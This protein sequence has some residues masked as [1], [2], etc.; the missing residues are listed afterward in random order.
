MVNSERLV[1]Y[2]GRTCLSTRISLPAVS[3][4][5][6]A[7]IRPALVHRKFLR[8]GWLPDWAARAVLSSMPRRWSRCMVSA[9][10]NPCALAPS[11]MPGRFY[12]SDA[13]TTDGGGVRTSAGIAAAWSSPFGPLKFSV[14]QPLNSKSG[15][16]IQRFQFQMGQ[17]F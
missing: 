15:D 5:Y 17:T 13:S 16:K 10:T 1:V 12:S 2:R 4:R 14:G 8:R 11:L 3:V 6:V 9:W 7:M